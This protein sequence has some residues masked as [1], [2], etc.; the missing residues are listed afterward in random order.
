MI[1]HETTSRP[2]YMSREP[3]RPRVLY[4]APSPNSNGTRTRPGAE[5]LR[6]VVNGQRSLCVG[7][8]TLAELLVSVGVIVL[9]VLLATQLLNS[10]ANITTLGQKQMD[11][12]S[13]ARQLLDRMAIDFA[14]M[15]KRSDVD[16]HVKSSATPP[17]TG[18]RN[19]LQPGNDTIAFYSAVPGY[20]PSGGSQSPVSL[21]AYRVNSQNKLERMGKGLLWNASTPTSG[22]TPPAVVFMPI[23]IASLLP[24]A[25]LPSPTPDPTSTPA[26]PE[27]AIGAGSSWS[28]TEV[29]GPQVFRFEYY[30]LLRG[31]TNPTTGTTYSPIFS[32]TPWDTR[33]CS[34]PSPGPTPTPIPSATPVPAPTPPLLCCHTA[35]EGMQDVAAIVVAIAVIDPKSKVLLS[36]AQ[37]SSL[38]SQLIDW[39]TTSCPGCPT[40]AQWQTTPGLLRA[41]WQNTLNAVTTLPRPAISGIRLYE[42]YMYLSP[43]TLLTP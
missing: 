32:D 18:V 22:A 41:Q 25:E 8:F 28:D 9:L 2:D 12:D 29:I 39:G 35:P 19:L 16:Y 14:Q 3:R 37:V 26:W 7:G 13:Q 21:V 1:D 31:Q 17:P 4:S 24:I 36:N 10:A 30:Y 6:S 38:A 27:I 15:V 42:R 33:I 34:C 40:Q 43:P 11:A 5:V 20:Y 23:P